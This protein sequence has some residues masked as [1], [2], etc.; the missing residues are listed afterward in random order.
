MA[1]LLLSGRLLMSHAHGAATSAK[2][3]GESVLEPM[4][5]PWA[6]GRPGVLSAL[7]SDSMRGPSWTRLPGPPEDIHSLPFRKE[8]E[9]HRLL[10]ARKTTN[11]GA[12]ARDSRVPTVVSPLRIA[13][14]GETKTDHF[15]QHAGTLYQSLDTEQRTGKHDQI[16]TLDPA[17]RI[18]HDRMVE[19]V[20]DV[21]LQMMRLHSQ[22]KPGKIVEQ[23]ED[24]VAKMMQM[25]LMRKSNF[26]PPTSKP[27][28]ASPPK[29]DLQFSQ[30]RAHGHD[31]SSFPDTLPQTS[32]SSSS[33]SSDESD[34]ESGSI[35]C[36]FDNFQT[37][38]NR[39]Q[40]A[41]AEKLVHVMT[42]CVSQSRMTRAW[43]NWKHGKLLNETEDLIARHHNFLQAGAFA[44]WQKH[45]HALFGARVSAEDTAALKRAS[46]IL[47]CL[48][49]WKMRRSQRISLQGLV[50]QHY[51]HFLSISF[52]LWKIRRP[53]RLSLQGLITEQYQ[54]TLGISFHLWKIRRPQ[55]IAVEGLIVEKHLAL[56]NGVFCSWHRDSAHNRRLNPITASAP[57]NTGDIAAA[58]VRTV[59]KEQ[60]TPRN[61][62]LCDL[63]LRALQYRRHLNAERRF[64]VVW[65][66]LVFDKKYR[67]KCLHPCIVC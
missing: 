6:D 37:L 47:F 48:H 42:S 20:E 21:V 59:R 14:E 7:Q 25:H 51:L 26:S 5:S 19:H 18:K 23:V 67:P 3:C 15:H 4:A 17:T 40:K 44:E 46:T 55:R 62:N 52:H 12:V 49:L 39:Q 27:T 41:G 50:V 63:K 35:E 53:Q 8:W 58:V 31:K 34:S 13:A 57:R 1:D 22:N 38:T 10:Q 33:N 64:I 32:D 54:R 56:L 11:T 36:G 43:E 16:Y 61:V 24:K 45:V 28:R 30:R 29:I 2:I 65:R 60:R 9:Q 66:R